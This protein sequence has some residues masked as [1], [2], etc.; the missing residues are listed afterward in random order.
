MEGSKEGSKLRMRRLD[1]ISYRE[2]QRPSEQHFPR[3]GT[4]FLSVSAHAF[5]LWIEKAYE[6][7]T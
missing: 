6:V 2:S 7:S 3:A 4:R 1:F 5:E